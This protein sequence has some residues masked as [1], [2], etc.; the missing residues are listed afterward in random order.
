MKPRRWWSVIRMRIRS[1]ARRDEVERDLEKE[2]RIHLEQEIEQNVAAGMSPAEARYA[3]LRRLGGV[4]QIKEECRDMRRTD[5]IENLLQDARYT[6]R[7]LAKSPGFAAAIVLTLALAIGANSA[8]FSVI[9]GVL[10]KP[11]PYPHA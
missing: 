2:L 7:T 4:A 5:Y 3:A 11:L 1:L 9:N 6:V 8:I 10:L